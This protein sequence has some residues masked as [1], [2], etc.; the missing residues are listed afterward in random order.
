M[1]KFTKHTI[2]FKSVCQFQLFNFNII[3]KVPVYHLGGSGSIPG[4][5]NTQL[6]SWNNWKEDAAFALTSANG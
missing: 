1:K 5:T 2:P 3:G 4:R 6:G